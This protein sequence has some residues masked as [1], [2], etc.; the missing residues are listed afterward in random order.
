MRR[1]VVSAVLAAAVLAGGAVPS[2][3]SIVA[4]WGEFNLGN[5]P[6]TE[7]L[8]GLS[9][10]ELGTFVHDYTFST[11]VSSYITTSSVT[12]SFT[13]PGQEI[14]GLSITLFSGA[15]VGSALETATASLVFPG[16]QAGGLLPYLIN[17]GTYYIEVAGTTV[18]SAPEDTAHYG[19]SF[20]ISAVP[21]PATW[22]MLILGF[23][24]VG[25]M[26]Y[27]RK[28]KQTGFRFA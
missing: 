22:A 25:F 24:G 16:F 8:G 14:T 28:D 7:G 21:E 2:R 12:N 1:F 20:S 6:A 10:S 9:L 3:A 13:V 17:P 15:P 23:M 18:G 26:A 27:R 4:A 19:G 5:T 11:A